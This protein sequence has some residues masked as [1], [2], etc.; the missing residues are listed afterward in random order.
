MQDQL[1]Q[2]GEKGIAVITGD[3]IHSTQIQGNEWVNNL[4]LV[5]EKEGQQERDWTIFG[6]DAFQLKVT[7][8]AYAISRAIFL[9]AEMYGKYDIQLRQAVGI[10]KVEHDSGKLATSNG[11]AFRYSGRGMDNIGKKKL[12]VMSESVGFDRLA[13]TMLALATKIMD[14]WT[15]RMAYIFYT[16]MSHPNKTQK[17]LA[18]ILK[19]RQSV[20]SESLSRSGFKEIYGMMH[21]FEQELTSK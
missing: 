18:K 7:N 9:Y 20:I 14:D 15:S 4:Q 11:T 13:G 12:I 5:L 1:V 8:P 17:E 16:K 21:Y 10:G 3:I 2:Q 19:V 6:G